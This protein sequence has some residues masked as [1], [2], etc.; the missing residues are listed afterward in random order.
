[1]AKSPTT[2]SMAPHA[3]SVVYPLRIF[4]AVGNESLWRQAARWRT[5]ASAT[6]ERNEHR[7]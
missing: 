7:G 5:S 3:G 2:N 1:M 4:D 6:I